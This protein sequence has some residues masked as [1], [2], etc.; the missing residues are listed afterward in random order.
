MN[1]SN[2]KLLDLALSWM[3]NQWDPY[4]CRAMEENDS[5]CSARK[6]HNKCSLFPDRECWIRYLTRDE[7]G[8]Q[9]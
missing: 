2:E 9:Q 7:K 4:P 1:V 8:D 6:M 5:Y 3:V